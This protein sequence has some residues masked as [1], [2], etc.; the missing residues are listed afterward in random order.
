MARTNWKTAAAHSDWSCTLVQSDS[1]CR[2]ASDGGSY[3]LMDSGARCSSLVCCH[4]LWFWSYLQNNGYWLWF[5]KLLVGLRLVGQS[6]LGCYS[7]TYHCSS[8]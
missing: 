6:L 5:W 8:L 4:Y 1:C 3:W 7:L 2:L